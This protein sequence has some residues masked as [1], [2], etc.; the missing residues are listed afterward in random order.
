L[1][2]ALTQARRVRA[3][4]PAIAGNH[5]VVTLPLESEVVVA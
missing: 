3:G 1:P 4:V 5:V 2:Y